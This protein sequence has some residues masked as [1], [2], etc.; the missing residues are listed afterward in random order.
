MNITDLPKVIDKVIDESIDK[1]CVPKD[2]N[3]LDLNNIEQIIQ[4]IKNNAKE[5]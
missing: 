1:N 3:I 4:W 5:V 2:M